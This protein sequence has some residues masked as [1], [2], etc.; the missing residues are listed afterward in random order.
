MPEPNLAKRKASTGATGPFLLATKL[1]S[2]TAGPGNTFR[3]LRALL[4]VDGMPLHPC[5]ATRLRE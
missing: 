3:L 5:L 2:A 4:V 1:T